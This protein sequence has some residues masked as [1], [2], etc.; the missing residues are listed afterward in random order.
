MQGIAVTGAAGKVGATIVQH[1]L[2]AGHEVHA[3]VH[4]SPPPEHIL[5]SRHVTV[6][7]L[8]LAAQEQEVLRWFH[9]ARPA[10]LIHSAAFADVPG[11]ERQPALAYL[12]NAQVTRMLA[13]AC[14]H[15]QTHFVMLS[16]EYVFGG[17]PQPEILCHEEDQPH[18][19]N[20]YGKSKAQGEVATQEECEGKTLWTI[21]RTSMVYGLT[22]P[23]AQQRPDFVQWIR[24]ALTRRETVQVATDQVNSPTYGANLAQMLVAVIQQRLPHIYHLAGR[25]ALSR[26]HFALEVARQYGLDASSIQPALTCQLDPLPQRPLNAGLCITKMQHAS[27]IRPLSV[28]E[29]IAACQRTAHTGG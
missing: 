2:E 7:A 6:T 5:A 13:R 11:C 20:H 4:S 3:L 25:T 26:Y 1:L 10:A 8:D 29:G 19:L 21:C 27:G 18:P 9:T 16:T 17:T 24:T 23:G 15:W 14:A 22:S 12:M 28:Q